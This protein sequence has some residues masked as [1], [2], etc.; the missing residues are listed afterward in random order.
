MA[1]T[2]NYLYDP[3]QEVYVIAICGKTSYV[4]PAKVLRVRAEALITGSTI[5]YDILVGEDRGTQ[6]FEESDVFADKTT[7]VAEYET[8]VS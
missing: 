5:K 3:N 6:E 7:A 1:G 8:R 2:I 4:S